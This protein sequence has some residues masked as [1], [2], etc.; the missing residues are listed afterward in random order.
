[1]LHDEKHDTRT[2]SDQE[3]LHLAIE[4]AGAKDGD[5]VLI[6]AIKTGRRPFGDR[7]M[8]LVAPHTYKREE[9]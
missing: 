2:L 3:I 7:R 9:P 5:T 6:L 4:A 1:M 8:V